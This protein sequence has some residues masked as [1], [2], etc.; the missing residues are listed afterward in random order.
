[1]LAILAGAAREPDIGGE[2]RPRLRPELREESELGFAAETAGLH[3]RIGDA[4]QGEAAMTQR[5]TQPM[6]HH[7][8]IEERAG[9]ELERREEPRPWRSRGESQGSFGAQ[10]AHGV[11]RASAPR[12]RATRRPTRITAST[13]PSPAG[14]RQLPSRTST[15]SPKASPAPNRRLVQMSVAA[16]TP[17]ANRSSGTPRKPHAV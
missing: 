15:R 9:P 17:S 5:E 1:R 10:R 4:G 12:R 16:T 2:H 11:T 8:R 7:R 3:Q 13:K 6:Q 14:Q